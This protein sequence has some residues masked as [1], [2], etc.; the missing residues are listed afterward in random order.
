MSR[1]PDPVFPA[2]FTQKQA[3]LRQFD[4]DLVAALGNWALS[5]KGLLDRGLSVADN[6]DA[7]VVSY[8]TNAVPDT[9]D[10]VAHGLGRVPTYFAVVDRDKGGV[11]YRS[12]TAFTKTTV[13][14]KTTV[15]GAAVKVIL[16]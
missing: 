5:L 10:A 4:R 3:E 15:A 6:M 13:Y 8:V 16:F 12:G 2:L 7:A 11:V 9:E 14:L 1:F